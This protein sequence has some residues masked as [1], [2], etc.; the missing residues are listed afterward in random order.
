MGTLAIRALLVG[1]HV[2]ETTEFAIIHDGFRT[3]AEGRLHSRHD[4]LGIGAVCAKPLRA[5]YF[6]AAVVPL[7]LFSSGALWPPIADLLRLRRP[8]GVGRIVG[9][10]EGFGGGLRVPVDP[11]TLRYC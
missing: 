9:F 5:G 10:L 3:F 11:K 4:W 7:W 6:G 8:R 2:F 1:K